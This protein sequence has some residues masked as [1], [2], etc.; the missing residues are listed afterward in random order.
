MILACPLRTFL[1]TRTLSSVRV[2]GKILPGA[3]TPV[4]IARLASVI[5]AA[6]RR[7]S[8]SHRAESPWCGQG[9][10]GLE[11]VDP[12]HL[13]LRRR[14]AAGNPVAAFSHLRAGCAAYGEK[15][16]HIQ[17]LTGSTRPRTEGGRGGVTT[18]ALI[19]VAHGPRR[20]APWPAFTPLELR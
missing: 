1:R 18:V 2:N 13:A 9:E 4:A 7:V 6:C 5:L 8:A 3:L 10:R 16:L 20:R 11:D 17:R 12:A 14:A 19:K 15:Y